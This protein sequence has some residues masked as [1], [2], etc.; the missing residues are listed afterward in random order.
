MIQ[1][2][3]DHGKVIASD[4]LLLGSRL[5]F[6][7]ACLFEH[8]LPVF[9]HYVLLLTGRLILAGVVSFLGRKLGSSL[10]GVNVLYLWLLAWH[11]VKVNLVHV[12]LT[13]LTVGV[14]WVAA[15]ADV[16]LGGVP[17]LFEVLFDSNHLLL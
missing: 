14:E 3:L 16:V 17:R 2:R 11:V 15:V 7:L 12:L 5:V 6:D 10:I 13:L 9:H 8:V 4:E 1:R